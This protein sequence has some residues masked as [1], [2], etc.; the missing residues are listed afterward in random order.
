MESFESK[1]SRTSLNSD[2]IL[3]ALE[4]VGQPHILLDV[5]D[6]VGSTNDI[7]LDYRE[8]IHGGRI[9]AVTAD[10]QVTG[11]GRLERQWTSPWGAGIA[12]S[13][14]VDA[15][16][17]THAPTSVPLIVGLS[18]CEALDTFGISSAVKWPNDVLL[19]K[20]APGKVCGVLVQLINDVFVIGIG[21]NCTLTQDELP[22]PLAT[23]L[24]LAGHHVEREILIAQVINRVLHNLLSSDD[25]MIAYTQNSATIHTDVRVHLHGD[26]QVTGRA[27]GINPDGSLILDSTDGI[28]NITLGDVEHLR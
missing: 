6:S 24:F 23:S 5:R 19:T 25:W 4:Q 9:V 12:L 3:Q 17:V 26:S 15:G 13:L 21:I 28:R 8:Q 16:R 22:T 10:E 11:R 27:I 18:V 7:V 2:A 14:G 20:S 1:A